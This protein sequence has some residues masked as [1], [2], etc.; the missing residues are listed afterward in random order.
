MADPASPLTPKEVEEIYKP[1]QRPGSP[2]GRPSTDFK[3]SAHKKLAFPKQTDQYTQSL[4]GSR[5]MTLR[6]TLTRP[7]LRADDS[8]IYG[9]QNGRT[10]SPRSPLSDDPMTFEPPATEKSDMMKGPFG[11]PDGWETPEKD[12]G[13]VR[14]LWNRVKSSQRKSS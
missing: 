10:K 9:W 11:G 4:A 7:D 3:Q 13:V 5:E 14:R 1:P 8:A 6:M 2:T 12:N